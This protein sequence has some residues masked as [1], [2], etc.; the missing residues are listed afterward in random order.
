MALIKLRVEKH[1]LS[2]R[3]T[4]MAVVVEDLLVAV[5]PHGYAC[6]VY[7]VSVGIVLAYEADGTEAK[8][9]FFVL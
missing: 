8:I 9:H 6:R 4:D 3:S 5:V 7:I 1:V 2:G